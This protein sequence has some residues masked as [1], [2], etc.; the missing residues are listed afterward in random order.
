MLEISDEQPQL[1]QELYSRVSEHL[2][3]IYPDLNTKKLAS[4]LIAEMGMGRNI[5]RPTP[6][7][8]HWDQ[9]D[10]ILI[11]YGNTIQS[12]GELPLVTLSRFLDKYLKRQFTAIHILPFFPFSSDDGFSVIDYSTVNPSL[13][14]WENIESISKKYKLM[15]DLVI[16]H[17]SSR[18]RWF[19]NYKNGVKP[20]KDYF[21]EGNPSDDFS[22]VVRPRNSPLLTEVRTKAGIRHVW[23]TFSGDQI[24]LNFRNPNV[25]KEFVS[26]VRSYLNHGI[27]IFRMDAV[28][29]L[30]KQKGTSCTNLQ[31]T[32]EI[33]K[34]FHTLIEYYF[35]SALIV[36]ENNVPSNENLT[37][38]GNA[39]EAHVIY[40]FS[41]PPLLIYTLLT[42]R[43]S[44]LQ[45]WMM[46]MPPAQS[47]TTYL[48]FIASHDGVG[49]RPLDGLISDDEVDKLVEKTK[50]SGGRVTY[51]K[52]REGSD[53]PYELNITLFDLLKST[54]DSDEDNYS[55][56]R[57]LC[58]HSIM[59]A[60]EG[61][62][63]V[64]IQSIFGSHNDL[65]RLEHTQRNRSINRHIWDEFELEKEL[66]DRQSPHA[67]IFAELKR[68][69]SIRK[70]QSAF[71]PNA[72]QYTLHIS[73]DIFAFWR[74]SIN[75]DQ[76]IF[77]ISNVTATEKLINLRDINLINTDEWKDLIGGRLYFN[78]QEQ[79]S[80]SPYQVLWISN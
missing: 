14:D 69:L 9:G 59:F 54:F 3:I 72:T 50:Q 29:F 44:H 36:C 15:S 74:Q 52:S 32:H 41:L 63:A 19:E 25:L 76:S 77:C 62:P 55:V 53:K 68:L 71:H 66:S 10:A 67:R 78:I 73:D 38:F 12:S 42:G 6:H 33:I 37:Y 65:E 30:W 8:N 75:R 18:S 5:Q 7:R 11:T 22:K 51:R 31:P 80:L 46:S 4:E 24:D 58:A 40:N 34:L 23:S 43:C 60:L 61:I 1:D 48:N 39:N 57:F 13:G 47:G 35:P 79:L 64:Y 20:G 27:T 16:N 28:P 49:L 45:N 17:I 26:I 70:K 2:S 56:E 21:I